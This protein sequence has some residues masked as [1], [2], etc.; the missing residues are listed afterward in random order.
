[1]RSALYLCCHEP[2]AWF[3]QS[4]RV[5]R[6][7]THFHSYGCPKC[8]SWSILTWILPLR[9]NDLSLDAWGTCIM[10]NV[11]YYI[12]PPAF[13][14]FPSLHFLS[15]S[16]LSSGRPFDLLWSFWL[17]LSLVLL[18]SFLGLL[19]VLP[20]FGPLGPWRCSSCS[21]LTLL[22]SLVHGCLWVFLLLPSFL[23][24]AGLLVLG[25]CTQFC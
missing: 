21:L 6:S 13:P 11:E 2:H 25:D 24:A 22:L 15:G 18:V 12:P 4:A 3:S 17:F 5:E 7:Q 20:G 1:M 19:F 10:Y 16:N 8:M 14:L 23:L 9:C